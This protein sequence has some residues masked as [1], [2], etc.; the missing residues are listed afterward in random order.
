MSLYKPTRDMLD[1]LRAASPPWGVAQTRR[2]G[3]TVVSLW[4]T[5]GGGYMVRVYAPPGLRK[6]FE[7]E[8]TDLGI[9]VSLYE[10][11]AVVLMGD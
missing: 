6:T 4:V 8:L 2:V 3:A 11:D 7:I 9:A 5:P 1:A 10:N